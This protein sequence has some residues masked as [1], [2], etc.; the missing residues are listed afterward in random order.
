MRRS[1]YTCAYNE[2]CDRSDADPSF[3]CWTMN[4][5]DSMCI[6]VVSGA[7]FSGLNEDEYYPHSDSFA[8][9]CNVNKGGCGAMGGFAPTEATAE[10]KWN[11]RAGA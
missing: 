8:A 3:A 1:C 11:T 10:I 6:E 7:E 9:V 5:Y 4:E 2:A